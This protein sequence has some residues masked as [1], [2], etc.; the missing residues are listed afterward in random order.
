M[1]FAWSSFRADPRRTFA[2]CLAGAWA[3]TKGAAARAKSH[4]AFM[5]RH[6]GGTVAYRSMVQSPIRRALGGSPHA[7]DRFR[8]ATYTTSVMGR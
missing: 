2:D 8:V 6:A 5:R 4:G 7:G 3:W 1:A